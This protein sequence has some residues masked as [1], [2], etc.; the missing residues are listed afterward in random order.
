MEVSMKRLKILLYPVLLLFVISA[1]SAMAEQVDESKV[2][3]KINEKEILSSDV[4][5]YV[6]KLIE[7]AKSTGQEVTPEME[8]DIRSQWIN[9][10]VAKELFL[11]QARAEKITVTDEEI[12]NGM[13]IAQTQGA[14]LP[15]EEL[16]AMIKDDLLISKVIETKVISKI[17]ITDQE[18]EDLYNSRKDEFKQ[19]E[20]IS[21]RHILIKVGPSDPQEKR[22][23]AKK[24]IESVL[25]ETRAS[26]DD[27][28]ELAKKYSEGPSGPNGGDLG[29]FTRGQMVPPFEEAAFKLDK[30][31]VSDVVETMFGY[32]IIKVEDKKEAIMI[33]FA[34]AK[35]DIK[36]YMMRQKSNEKIETWIKEL[37]EKATIEIF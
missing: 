17:V 25:A 13:G 18:S 34:D 11:Q 35:E 5:F 8:K 14:N 2:V 4:D 16:K 12:E 10:L 30:G 31:G 23:A 27:F 22:D 29:F 21:A 32:H 20:Q 3:A 24:K 15:P 7:R 1:C 26:K 6:E 37:K 19:P 33:P 36:N 28:G 9:R